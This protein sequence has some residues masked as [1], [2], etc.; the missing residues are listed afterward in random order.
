MREVAAGNVLGETRMA[1]REDYF[2]RT[3]PEL[4]ASIQLRNQNYRRRVLEWFRRGS[5][6]GEKRDGSF[7][8]VAV[9]SIDAIV[10]MT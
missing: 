8:S 2:G 10:H 5:Y 9:G 4:G 6:G 7:R 3:L 1:I